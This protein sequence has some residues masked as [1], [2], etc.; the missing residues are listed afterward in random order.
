MFPKTGLTSDDFEQWQ[1]VS[2][3]TLSSRGSHAAERELVKRD[4]KAAATLPFVRL[5]N[6]YET[7]IRI[8]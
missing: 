4:Y 7:P 8:S 6:M 2:F 5:R 3:A 1:Y